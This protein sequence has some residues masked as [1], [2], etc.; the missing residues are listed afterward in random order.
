MTVPSSPTP[1]ALPRDVDGWLAHLEALHPNVIELGLERVYRV[2][3]A[4]GLQPA[5][6]VIIVGG[7][8]GKGSVCALL[9]RIYSAAGFRVGCYTSPHLV[10]YH[11]RMR[12]DLAPVSDD[13]LC[14][15]FEAVERGRGDTALTYFEFG[16]LAAVS[17]FLDAKVD[18]MI[19]EV[20][21][22]G[23]LDA[24]NAFDADCS[25]VTSVDLDHQAFLGDT[26]EAIGFEKAGI[27]RAGKPA[28]CADPNPPATLVEHA[29]TIGAQWLAI[30]E[31]FGFRKQDTQWEAWCGDKRY[32]SLPFP[33]LRGHYQLANASAA[34][35]AL[36]QLQDRVPVNMGA[37][38]RGLLEV[39]LPGRFQVLPG[40]P[41]VVLDVGH[42]PHAA[43][44]LDYS[45]LQMGFYE[46]TTAVCGMM[47]D[48]DMDAVVA[49]LAQ[50]IDRWYVC[51]LPATLRAATGE[52][53]AEVVR[54]HGGQAT[55]FP[56][57]ADAYRAAL[58]DGGE[59]DRVVVFG[60]FFTVGDVLT[61]RARQSARP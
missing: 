31:Q 15:S 11:E 32:H 5:C 23:R 48:K 22:G 45:L 47:R 2:R 46:R 8:N 49:A 34:L 54:R 36:T 50:R 14:R 13:G 4:M 21:L 43:R 56:T 27:Y 37:I 18:V 57:A 24:V 26:R 60:S 19:L 42:N 10:R 41:A 12:I 29:R 58:A 25:V 61:E 16:T 40:R 33:A 17:A 59:R 28:I 39:E 1:G 9:E 53:L 52:E 30:G 20:G 44:A 3:D 38:R 6:P 35:A 7:T 51:D 55:V